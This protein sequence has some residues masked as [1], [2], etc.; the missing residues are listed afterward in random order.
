LEAC[1]DTNINVVPVLVKG[2]I[3]HSADAILSRTRIAKQTGSGLLPL[4]CDQES[5]TCVVGAWPCL[6]DK[7]G[8]IRFPSGSVDTRRIIWKNSDLMVRFD[9]FD[10]TSPGDLKVLE[11]EVLRA[12]RS[13]PG[14]KRC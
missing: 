12:A 1:R 8:I 5:S 4:P 14:C 3:P 11:Q 6:L 9:G 7:V 2:K 13:R 10:P